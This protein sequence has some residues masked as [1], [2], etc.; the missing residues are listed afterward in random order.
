MII[1]RLH[2]KPDSAFI[3]KAQICLGILMV[4]FILGSGVLPGSVSAQDTDPRKEIDTIYNPAGTTIN[5]FDYYVYGPDWDYFNQYHRFPSVTVYNPDYVRQNI[6]TGINSIDQNP[7]QRHALF[8]YQNHYDDYFDGS[9]FSWEQNGNY[10]TGHQRGYFETPDNN[11]PWNLFFGEESGPTTGF[12]QKT[13]NNNGYPVVVNGDSLESLDYLFNTNSIISRI[14]NYDPS[15]VKD[16]YEKV[17]KLFTVDTEGFYYFNSDIYDAEFDPAKVAA[18]R[19]TVTGDDI[20]ICDSEMEFKVLEAQIPEDDPGGAIAQSYPRFTP[21]GSPGDHLPNS[22][23]VQHPENFF[24]GMHMQVENFS[25]PSSGKVLSPY[26]TYHDMIFD[27]SGDDDVWIFLNGV[28]IGD[29][30]GIHEAQEININFTTNEVRSWNHI[31]GSEET[32]EVR[33]L[34]QIIVDA[35]GTDEASRLFDW[36]GDK[37]ITN[38][39]YLTLDFFYLER[40]AS[41][42]NLEIRYNLISSFDFTAH[43]ALYRHQPATASETPIV[44]SRDDFRFKLTGFDNAP[45]PQYDGDTPKQSQSIC[46]KGEDEDGN[47]TLTCGTTRM[48]YAYFGD[49]ADTLLTQLYSEDKVYKYKIE[50]VLPSDCDSHGD[51]T[52]Y[53]PS[54]EIIYDEKPIYFIGKIMQETITENGQTRYEYW[55]SKTITDE[56]FEPIDPPSGFL[57]F[58]NYRTWIQLEGKKE[59]TNRDP[60]SMKK[61]EFEFKMIEKSNGVETGREWT[62]TSDAAAGDGSI[63]INYPVLNYGLDDDGWHEDG[64]Y[65]M[66]V[67]T[68]TIYEVPPAGEN[69]IADEN[70]YDS[71]IVTVYADEDGLITIDAG[72]SGD[73][74]INNNG[75]IV[76]L[77]FKNVYTAEIKLEGTKELTGKKLEEGM[78]TFLIEETT[79]NV[80]HPYT[81]EVFNDAEGKFT[82]PTITYDE[83]GTYTYKVIEI[84]GDDPAISYDP[85]VY[86]I[87]VV[88]AIDD[89]DGMLKA[90]AEYKADG[91][92]AEEIKFTNAYSTKLPITGTKVLA[93]RALKEDEFVFTI[94]EITE[95][96][97]DPFTAVAVNDK[98]GGFSF[99]EITYDKPGEYLYEVREIPGDDLD[100]TYDGTVFTVT[101]TVGMVQGELKAIAAYKADSEDA[102]EIRF[103]NIYTHPTEIMIS[104]TKVLT[105]RALKEDEF[106][107]R[108]TETTPDA[109]NPFTDI[110]VNNE[111]GEFSFNPITYTKTGTYTY[112]VSEI[113]GKDS[114]ITYD[115]TEYYVAVVVTKGTGKLNAAVTYKYNDGEEEGDAE[116]IRFENVCIE[117]AEIQ[118]SGTKKLTGARTQPK[119]NEFAFR[120]EE[121]TADAENPYTAL[122][123]NAAD[124]TYSFDPI[125]FTKAGT[126]SYKV[127]EVIGD[128]PEVRYDGTEYEITVTVEYKD[129]ELSAAAVVSPETEVTG[130]DFEN[131]IIEPA[132]IQFSGTKKLTGTRTQPRENEFVFRLEETTADAE[133]PYTALALNAADGTYSFDPISFTK[134][135]TYTYKVTEVSGSDPDVTYDNFAYEITVTVEEDGGVLTPT[136]VVSPEAEV[137][138]LDFENSI[139]EDA[140]CE[141]KPAA[142]VLITGIK[143]LTGRQMKE[144]EFV[145]ELTETSAGGYTDKALNDAAGAFAFHPIRYTEPG[146]YTYKVTEVRGS[147]PDVTYDSAVYEVTVTVDETAAGLTAAVRYLLDGDEADAIEFENEI[148]GSSSAEIRFSGIK[149][150]SGKT[151]RAGEFTF[152]LAETTAGAASPVTRTASNDEIGSFTFGYVTYDEPGTYTYT[153]REIAG[154]DPSITYDRTVY[155]ITVTV[156]D[157]FTVSADTNT[158]ALMF[159][160]SYK[161]DGGH[162]WKFFP[163]LD[164]LPETGF[165]ALRNTVLPEQPLS[166][167]YKP[168]NWSIEIPS[169]NLSADIVEVPFTDDQYPV[170]W[171]GSA[172]GLPEGLPLPG[173]GKAVLVGHNHL[174]MTEAGPFAMLSSL[175]VGDRFF[176]RGD[177]NEFVPFVIRVNTKIGEADFDA[178]RKISDMDE[179]SLLLITCEDE[180][181][182]GGYANRRIVAAVPTM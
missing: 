181:A 17:D 166:I 75:D 152:E 31:V 120:L 82:F 116:E 27:F 161:M 84:P 62:F 79:E 134:A 5:M 175:S 19:S 92:A 163:L 109:A 155:H 180:R 177:K 97:S 94:T 99:G 89:A 53:S 43:K 70:I 68:Y 69:I 55:M 59:I 66:K 18:C 162:T 24:F 50:E 20:G 26:G 87:T 145:F 1:R 176:I 122:A 178:F 14:G 16:V 10:Y 52:C 56:K 78:F 38:S 60:G 171:L 13:L 101:V 142:E 114:D 130:L 95:G 6:F 91:K 96:V 141:E 90:A 33:T 8:F 156:S 98:N 9:D 80:D 169:L 74:T 81:E 73:G 44:L 138:G 4:L 7:G 157:D 160:N 179:R 30:G 153:I 124:G 54:K 128:D 133:K 105:N 47:R 41:Y 22:M 182:E 93:N 23:E 104:G 146:T 102:E 107:F 88:V 103:E 121:T 110:A 85:T 148:A 51:G 83:P 174:N 48:G 32:A 158:E 21:F 111:S 25:I 127:T 35:V 65:Y 132:E 86:E 164:H 170:T 168:V 77:D 165:S 151:L 72:N 67:Y 15:H 139:D 131:I 71:V 63:S 39:K 126:Y 150:L 117:P 125:S 115:I 137:S 36:E 154:S 159:R 106:V 144:N 147:D 143:T 40:G 42:S 112:T 12:V 57:N 140:R 123:L 28:L 29:L 61:N 58:E 45:M 136:A 129:G 113:P 64:S 135:G 167:S 3:S 76:G 100:I 37:L 172:V 108:I 49:I 149:T 119:A 46:E 118:F 34:R 173:E 2:N 11:Q